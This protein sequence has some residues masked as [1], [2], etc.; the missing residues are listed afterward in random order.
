MLC[1]YC[2]EEINEKATVCKHCH[3][4]LLAVRPFLDRVAELERKVDD[5]V[6]ELDQRLAVLESMSRP[7]LAVN[8]AGSASGHGLL[9]KILSGNGAQKSG[10]ELISGHMFLFI[11]PFLLLLFFHWVIIVL[12]DLSP[13]FLRIAAMLIPLPFGVFSL[14]QGNRRM[15]FSLLFAFCLAVA[16]VLGMSAITGSVD[17]TPVL[18]RDVREWREMFEFAASI[19]FSFLTGL[20]IGRWILSY[21]SDEIRPNAVV[22]SLARLMSK[23]EPGTR[24]NLSEAI[25]RAQDLA[26][27]LTALTSTLA[28]VLT[29]IKSMTDGG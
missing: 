24:P 20:L 1:P 15:L 7:G 9:A 16:T 10:F 11:S 3:S 22:M 17:G 23:S 19:S 2:A 27:A 12:Y 21:R 5:V 29:G 28:T 13:W 26:S 8:E 6:S 18:P 14:L 25:K 4:D